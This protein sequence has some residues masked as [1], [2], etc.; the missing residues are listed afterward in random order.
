MLCVSLA[1][2]SRPISIPTLNSILTGAEE[3]SQRIF[4]PI[5]CFATAIAE[6]SGVVV[7]P[8]RQN[9]YDVIENAPIADQDRRVS[10]NQLPDRMCLKFFPSGSF[11]LF[12]QFAISVLV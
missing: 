10:A 8:V 7:N 12:D 11:L 3:Y 2:S 1:R 6:P 9:G 4:R 5:R